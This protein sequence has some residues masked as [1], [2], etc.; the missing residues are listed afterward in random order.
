[1][2]CDNKENQFKQLKQ[3]SQEEELTIEEQKQYSWL[4]YDLNTYFCKG[5]KP[6]QNW[7]Y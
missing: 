5:G 4:I 7:S 6:K 1:M 2:N 3:K